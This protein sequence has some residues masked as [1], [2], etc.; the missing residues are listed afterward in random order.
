MIMKMRQALGKKGY[1]ADEIELLLK[2][3]TELFDRLRKEAL[4]TSTAA[5]KTDDSERSMPFARKQVARK[6][7]AD[8]A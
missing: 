5:A 6:A 2:S 7:L 8:A 3:F 4:A 1:T